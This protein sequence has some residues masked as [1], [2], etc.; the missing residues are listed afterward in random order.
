MSNLNQLI[1]EIREE[2]KRA[3]KE[4]YTYNGNNYLT[5]LMKKHND[6]IEKI[7][8]KYAAEEGQN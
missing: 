4:I 1:E 5:Q 6:E 7:I 2:N 8:S 3:L